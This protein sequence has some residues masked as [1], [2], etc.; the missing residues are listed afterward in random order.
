[1]IKEKGI[2]MNV[3]NED[4]KLL[5]ESP[6]KFWEGVTEI[7]PFAFAMFVGPATLKSLEVP[8]SVKKIES[9]GF[10]G[11]YLENLVLHGVEEICDYAFFDSRDLKTIYIP[12]NL[13]DVIKIN[14]KAFIFS[15]NNIE[16]KTIK[17]NKTIKMIQ[18]ED[19][20]VR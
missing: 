3:T 13:K 4:I 2:L 7:G 5:K 14:K 1:M 6:D 9:R 11:T 10:A 16:I 18:N 19:D 8:S 20:L 15:N 12:E 17:T